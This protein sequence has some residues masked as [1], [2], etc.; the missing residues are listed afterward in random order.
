[1]AAF[2]TA[3]VGPSGSIVIDGKTYTKDQKDDVEKKTGISAKHLPVFLGPTG[4]FAAGAVVANWLANTDNP[5]SGIAGAVA[6]PINNTVDFLDRISNPHLWKRIG[7][8]A[9]GILCFYFSIWLMV[10]D[11]KAGKAVTSAVTKAATK[12]VV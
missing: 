4:G 3:S 1:M 7:V 10:A 12:G 2:K 5:V 9:L 6:A 8:I 11:T